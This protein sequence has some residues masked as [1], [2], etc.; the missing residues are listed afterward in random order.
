MS[1]TL[2]HSD[3][4]NGIP[5]YLFICYS[6]YPASKS[7]MS[8][9]HCFCH[10]DLVSYSSFYISSNISVSFET[11]SFSPLNN[12]FPVVPLCYPGYCIYFYC[13]SVGGC[14]VGNV[15][16]LVFGFRMLHFCKLVVVHFLT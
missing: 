7:L 14:L 5:I 12:P 11:S 16:L 10:A 9:R 15:L 3:L 1:A 4:L 6:V 8:I 2:L 13:P